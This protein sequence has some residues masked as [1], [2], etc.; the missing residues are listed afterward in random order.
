MVRR[1]SL[2]SDGLAHVANTALLAVWGPRVHHV[3]WYGTWN[4]L[5]G[6]C[7]STS[8]CV[9]LHCPCVQVPA[10]PS[11]MYL[12]A[13]RCL[14]VLV[15]AAPLQ[16][17]RAFLAHR[18][19]Y[20]PCVRAVEAFVCAHSRRFCDT[21]ARTCANR[22]PWSILGRWRYIL[23]P[24]PSRSLRE[25]W[26]SCHPSVHWAVCTGAVQLGWLRC[27]HLL[28][29]RP[30]LQCPWRGIEPM[31]RTLRFPSWLLLLELWR[32]SHWCGVPCRYGGLR[33]SW[34]TPVAG[35]CVTCI[36]FFVFEASLSIRRPSHYARY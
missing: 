8:T 23:L 13:L 36:S 15:F 17:M 30:V 27:L 19:G 29:G 34:G 32:D 9:Y 16:D 28:S 7:F 18:R 20:Q 3:C 24:V 21:T 33:P 14:S 35:R 1:W 4:S 5:K 12:G 11:P 26:G 6:L 2:V 31:L 25:C 10:A 22:P